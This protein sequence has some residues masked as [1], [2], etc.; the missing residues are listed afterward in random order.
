[1]GAEKVLAETAVRGYKSLKFVEQDIRDTKTELEL[2]RCF[3]SS[4]TG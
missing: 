4:K 3:T 2:G 1:M